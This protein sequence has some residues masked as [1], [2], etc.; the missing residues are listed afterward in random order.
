MFE[1]DE[2]KRLWTL[3]ERGLDFIDAQ[4]I[5]DGRPALHLRAQS[6]DEERWLTSAALR[7]KMYTVVWTWRGTTKRIISFRRARRAE[8]VAYEKIFG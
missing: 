2:A 1:W 8:E 7:G 4:E 6:F 3:A 5:F